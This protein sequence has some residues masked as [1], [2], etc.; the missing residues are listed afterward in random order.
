MAVEKSPLTVLNVLIIQIK[1]LVGIHVKKG[2]K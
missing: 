2:V 1:W